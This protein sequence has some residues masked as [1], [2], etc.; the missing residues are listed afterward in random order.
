MLTVR[1]NSDKQKLVKQNNCLNG[2]NAL[3]LV[4]FVLG[5]CRKTSL[6]ATLILQP[7]LKNG[8]KNRLE[9]AANWASTV[10]IEYISARYISPYIT[11]AN[12]AR[13][14]STLFSVSGGFQFSRTLRRMHPHGLLVVLVIAFRSA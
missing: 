1:D 4:G 14:I 2:T 7:P 8:T 5:Q 3:G 6:I 9:S 10:Y 13:Y 11:A 12:W